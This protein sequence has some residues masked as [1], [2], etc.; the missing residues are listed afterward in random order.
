MRRWCL[1]PGET[2]ERSGALALDCL[3]PAFLLSADADT[4]QSSARV[5]TPF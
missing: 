1:V 4:G 2:V 3:A 5:Q